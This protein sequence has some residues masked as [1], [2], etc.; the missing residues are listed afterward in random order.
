MKTINDIILYSTG[1]P[2]CEVL[3]KKLAEKNIRYT[4]DNDVNKMTDLGITQ[5]PVLQTEDALLD[6]QNAVKWINGQ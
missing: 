4:E 6:F 3:K 2:K 1:C 5:V